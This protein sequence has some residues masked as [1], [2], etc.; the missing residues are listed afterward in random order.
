MRFDART[1]ARAWLAVSLASSSDADR[2]ALCRAVHV[3]EFDEGIRLVA[4]DA[5]LLLHTWV[6]ALDVDALGEPSYDAAPRRTF[7]ALDVDKRAN[8]MCRHWLRTAG[9]DDERVE[10]AFGERTV[11]GVRQGMFDGLETRSAVLEMPGVE[12]LI[13]RIYEGEWPAWRSVIPCRFRGL[14]APVLVFPDLLAR[15]GKLGSL[16]K[17]YPVS[18]MF[19]GPKG[20]IRLRLDAGDHVIEGV[21]SPVASPGIASEDVA[22]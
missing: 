13:L 19:D 9:D 11:P 16:F 17:T 6:P 1:F 15:L 18:F 4:T 2:P 10:I 5:F 21:M 3:E 14:D 22:A 7:T 12:R 20:A 8:D